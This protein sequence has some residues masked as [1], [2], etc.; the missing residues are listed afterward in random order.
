MSFYHGIL[1]EK[2]LESIESME[3]EYSDGKKLFN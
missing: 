2:S 1:D 3:E